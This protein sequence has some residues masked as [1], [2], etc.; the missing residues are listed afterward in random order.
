MEACMYLIIPN[1]KGIISIKSDVAGIRVKYR[2][3][4]GEMSVNLAK[5]F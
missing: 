2:R 4:A 1:T 5:E 3:N